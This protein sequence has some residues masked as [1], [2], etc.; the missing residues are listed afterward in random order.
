[1]TRLGIYGGTFSPPHIGHIEA[2]RAFCRQMA[3]DRLLIIPT[4]IPPHKS[5]EGK[6]PAEDRLRMCELAFSELDAAEISDMEI[7]RTGTSYTYLTLEELTSPDTELFFL[8]G[9]DMI[10]T[11]DSWRYPERIFALSTIC[12]MRRE[13]DALIGEE[14]DAKVE[15]YRARFGAR[16][17]RI[18]APAVQ[19][20]SSEVRAALSEGREVCRMLEEK[21][22]GYIRERGLYL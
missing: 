18:E 9:T 14:I 22:L 12:Y 1:M 4:N 16:I 3:L 17:I 19:M 6:A 11:M 5:G 13:S 7:K 2:A 8:C 15:E 21:T 20:S 10:L